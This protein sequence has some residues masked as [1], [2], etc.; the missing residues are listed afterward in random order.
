MA[1]TA[2]RGEGDGGEVSIRCRAEIPSS[3]ER[4]RV[5]A[6][7]TQPVIHS[8]TLVATE[9]EAGTGIPAL[10]RYHRRAAGSTVP[11]RIIAAPI[12]S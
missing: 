6:W 5:V 8:L 1:G 2:A 4:E 12:I 3:Y 10:P 11:T 9:Y 7:R